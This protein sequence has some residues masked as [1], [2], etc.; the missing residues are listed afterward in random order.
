[1]G[2][3]A[4]N[5]FSV[6][7]QPITDQQSKVFSNQTSL[8]SI[9]S[10][11]VVPGAP[12]AEFGDK[13]SVVIVATTRSG[14]GVN[15]P[16]GS[17]TTSYGTFGSAN[18]GFNLAYGQDKWRNFISANGLN[19]SRFLDG[20]EFTAM[21]DR[22]NQENLFDRLDFKPSPNNTVNVNFG[23]TRS[24]FQTPNS[25]D[26]QGAT[27]WSGLVVDNGGFGPDGRLVG[28]DDQH[29]Q[30]RTLNIAPTLTRVINANTVLTLGGY[31]RQDQSNYYPSANPFADLTPGLQAQTVGQNRTLT[32]AG[33][34]ASVSYV[35]GNHNLKAGANFQHTFL[36]EN[37]AFGIVDPTFNPVCFNPDGSPDT[38]TM[39]TY[40]A[41]CNQPLQANPGFVPLLA[42]YD[43]TRTG[44]LPASDSCPNPA[45]GLYTFRGH[46]D[47]KEVALFIQDTIKAKNWVFNL[48]LRGDI[49]N[50]ITIARQLQ[51]RVGVAYNIK[52]TKTVLRASYARTMETPFNENLV[53]ACNGCNDPVVNA[54]MSIT[55]G[56]ARNTSR[57]GRGV[58]SRPSI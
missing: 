53:L 32:N 47:I 13:T 34:H 42:C 36:T 43:L 6:D 14:L 31:V 44:S 9:Q 22:G 11:E 38:N 29:S 2:D 10:L 35:K 12:P 30:I 17:I 1:M 54:L 26:S 8:D 52:H 15:K 21:H 19:T 5:S 49:Y 57:W 58:R 20:P 45:S 25:Y 39:L 41:N 50:G 51:P 55:Q 46:S 7:G 56:Y 33:A 16:T 28:S 27:A 18:A 23:L 48:G 3:H 4:S 24:W 37:D 40:P